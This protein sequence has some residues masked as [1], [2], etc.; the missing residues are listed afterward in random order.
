MKPLLTTL[1]LLFA[2]TCYSQQRVIVDSITT[3]P[4]KIYYKIERR[5]VDTTGQVMFTALELQ[6]QIAVR[7]IVL[8]QFLEKSIRAQVPLLD[9][10]KNDQARQYAVSQIIAQDNQYATIRA[11]MEILKQALLELSKIKKK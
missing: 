11:D 8:K 9:S 4:A 7:E 10:I 2:L 5:T 1:L 3:D 6:Q